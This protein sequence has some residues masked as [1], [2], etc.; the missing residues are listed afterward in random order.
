MQ[1][2]WQYTHSCH[3]I[4]SQYCHPELYCLYHS[5]LCFTALA[6]ELGYAWSTAWQ[7]P[8]YEPSIPNNRYNSSSPRERKSTTPPFLS[9]TVPRLH[10]TVLTLT[11]G[12]SHS[13]WASFHWWDT[14]CHSSYQL[15]H[16]L[17][18]HHTTTVQNNDVMMTTS[19]IDSL[20]II[21]EV[22]LKYKHNP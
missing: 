10:T 4:K 9:N 18:R 13:L 15:V 16:T 20:H 17:H 8:Y 1:L 5:H 12:M 6:W 7:Y 22:E 2:P 3:D 21:R 19:R 11:T 14:T